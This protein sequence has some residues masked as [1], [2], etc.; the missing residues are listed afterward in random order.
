MLFLK[1][2][3]PNI[4]ME[5]LDVT[6]NASFNESFNFSLYDNSDYLDIS[7][8]SPRQMLDNLANIKPS[9]DPALLPIQTY[10]VKVLV[11]ILHQICCCINDKVK[12]LY[13]FI[14]LILCF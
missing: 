6:A 13:N 3:L 10:E 11:R 4:S 5:Q 12:I 2:D 1:V 9:I 7:R 8:V 14:N